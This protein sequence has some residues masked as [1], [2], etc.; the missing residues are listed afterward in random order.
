VGGLVNNSEFALCTL[1]AFPNH[2][3]GHKGQALAY[4]YFEDK[5]GRR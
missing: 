2:G 5:P 4:V 3:R 1:V